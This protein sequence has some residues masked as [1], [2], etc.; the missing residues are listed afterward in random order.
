MA[1]TL[2]WLGHATFRLS[3]DRIIYIDPWKVARAETADVVIV[4]HEH[5]DHL[6][7]EDVAK[8]QGPN[9]VVVT[10]PDC[11]GKI[12]Q[13]QVR[14]LTP[15]GK[16]EVAGVSIYGVPAYNIGKRFHPQANNWLGVVVEW[17]GRRIYYAGDTDLVPE[18]EQLE[19]IDVGL[20]PVG[21]TYTMNAQEAAQ[22]AAKVGC[23]LAIPYHWGDIVGSRAD[24][25]RFAQAWTG[26]AKILNP[27]ESLTLP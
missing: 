3:D 19:D 14:T 11:A 25:E 1:I 21:G 20:F 9:T 12:R 5:F 15:G 26:E 7:P 16:V 6:S 22:A 18:M 8:L 13:G 24:A 17:E 23:K 2:T 10:T 27:G 4:S